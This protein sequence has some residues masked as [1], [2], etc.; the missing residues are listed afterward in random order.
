MK[1]FIFLLLAVVGG[2]ETQPKAYKI[3]TVTDGYIVSEIFDVERS[4]YGWK[5]LYKLP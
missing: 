2:C 4:S 3:T 5:Y 1:P